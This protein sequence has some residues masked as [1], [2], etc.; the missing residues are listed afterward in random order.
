MDKSNGPTTKT[1]FL[2]R[3]SD[4]PQNSTINSNPSQDESAITA[5]LNCRNLGGFPLGILGRLGLRV[6]RIL[7]IAKSKRQHNLK[8]SALRLALTNSLSSQLLPVYYFR[9]EG[10]VITPWNSGQEV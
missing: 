7:L 3:W 4:W 9:L 6:K 8:K 10:S 1:V 2:C 5:I